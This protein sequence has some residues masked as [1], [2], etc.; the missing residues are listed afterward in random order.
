MESKK[1]E[2]KIQATYDY[3]GKH[4]ISEIPKDLKSLKIKI[5]ELYHL[6]DDQIN[7]YQISY[8]DKDEDK[9]FFIMDEQ[10]FKKAKLLSEEII[11]TI[12]DIFE[13]KDEIID[14]QENDIMFVKENE[15]IIKEDKIAYINPKNNYKKKYNDKIQSENIN[16]ENDFI[17][18]ITKP[19][20][21]V[22]NLDYIEDSYDIYVNLFEIKLKK[23]IIIYQYPFTLVP[24][25]EPGDISTIKKIFNSCL[26][27]LKSI[28]GECFIMGNSLYGFNRVE[29]IKIV[30]T[31]LRGK[32][33]RCEFKIEFGKY[34][35]S[36]IIKQNDIQN[37]DPI[38]KLYI[39]LLI[40]DI[41]SAN[42]KL[43]YYK[44]LFIKIDEKEII[45]SE[46]NNLSV[47]FYPGFAT[48]F[49]ET[50]TGKF[51]NVSLKN[52]IIQ[53]ETILDYL[54]D[55]GYKNPQKR[56]K[57]R[58]SLIDETFKPSYDT[59]NYRI[60]DICFDRNPMNQSFNL[61]GVGTI[62][63][64]DYYKNIKG[65]KIKEKDQPLL[66]VKKTDKEK[67]PINLYFIPS[68]CHF[69]GL[70]DK[71]RKDNNF[72]RRLADYTKLSPKDRVKR[73]NQF[74]NLLKDPEKRKGELSPK[75]KSEIYGIKIMPLKDSFQ[76]YQIKPTKLIAGNNEILKNKDKVFPLLKKISMKNWVC[77]YEKSNY[78]DADYLYKTLQKSS[79]GYGL[80]IEE[81]L[82][83]E[84]NDHSHYKDWLETVDDY[85]NPKYNY[86]FFVFLFD[87]NDYIYS[88]LKKHSLC[89]NGYVSQ[90]VKV[91]SLYKNP[92][93]VCSKILLQI[94]AKLGGVNYKIKIDKSIDKRKLMVIGFDSSHIRG[95][96][97][98]VAMVAT[99]DNNFTDFYNNEEIIEEINKEQL[100]FKVST[101]IVKAINEFKKQNKD[102]KP[103]NIIIYR[104]GVS[105][106]Q[107]K[108]L[109]NEIKYIDEVCKQ[110]NILY[111][112][113]LVNT[114]V[115]YKFFAIDQNQYYNPYPG[116][117]VID[118]VTHKNFFEF[119]IQ[120]QSVTGGSATP[121]CFHVAYGNM[122]FPEFLPK[123][124]Y[125][126]CHLYSN[127]LGPVR[128]PNVIKAAEKLAKMTAKYTFDE[129]NDNLKFGQ[130]YL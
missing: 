64:F 3:K 53:K 77:L 70:N 109:K 44:R 56:E 75:E 48:S 27:E 47:I 19:N 26:R 43:D 90:V 69:T 46:Q 108:Y 4:E 88:K 62:T 31:A 61:Y 25:V 85:I 78:D 82:W 119:Y 125:D 74:L 2:K 80:I 66:V 104:Q 59:K 52:K 67:N 86:K 14:E 116:L 130:S 49:V 8:Q 42:T 9:T 105:L 35:N 101:F 58:E 54:N 121:T 99:L 33:G 107:K 100:Q 23:D 24:E 41:L 111:Y 37:D 128:M 39:E 113:I 34:L 84:M 30:K 91:K 120:P 15:N 126:L 89:T 98:A 20:M 45:E 22:E 81:P 123:F 122:D 57:I 106:Q 11:F 97:T 40:K 93:S 1:E 12:E 51:L 32:K 5:K 124:T 76:A 28:F 55:R 16:N 96:R 13:Q 7:K 50:Q 68:L 87:G 83:I 10:D 94:N 63:L 36:R 110:N 112:Y 92:M 114:K 71:L 118:G 6:N 18:M 115:N 73:T 102:N 72:M 65:I 21:D 103:K 38:C 29:E 60:D 117:L 79:K 17:N 127:W 129:L 95:K